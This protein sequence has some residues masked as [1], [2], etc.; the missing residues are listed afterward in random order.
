MNMQPSTGYDPGADE[1]EAAL[2][3]TLHRFDCPATH[4]VG[5]YGLGLLD[6]VQATLVAGHVN[7][8]D[9]CR[10]ELQTLRAFL[11]DPMPM[12][13]PVLER[14]RRIVAT[15]FTPAPGLAL[16]GLRG[17]AAS[18]AGVYEVDNVTLTLG[19]GPSPG[20]LI[21]LVTVVGSLPD[22]LMGRG[23][24]LIERGGETLTSTVD[25]LGNF[26]FAGVTPGQ[27][28]LEVELPDALV[29][30]QELRID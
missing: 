9:A 2:R 13:M 12:P 24:R 4:A 17:N 5:E 25:D 30:V 7:E 26:E 8:C 15:L 19:P 22:Q 1:F 18:T 23:V 16:G 6:P 11:A 29:V 28:A 10:T 21:G 27:Y 20:T 3:R 14:A